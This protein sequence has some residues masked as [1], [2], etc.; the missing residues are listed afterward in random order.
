MES[1]NDEMHSLPQFN[2][3]FYPTGRL[4]YFFLYHLVHFCNFHHFV[5]ESFSVFQSLYII[6]WLSVIQYVGVNFHHSVPQNS[7]MKF[8][9]S[10][11]VDIHTLVWLYIS[12]T[13]KQVNCLLIYFQ[14]LT[15][16]CRVNINISSRA[17]KSRHLI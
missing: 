13:P 12:M 4:Y 10:V 7:I 5:V 15:I 2:Y 17:K 14:V 11:N 1:L 8:H 3:L 9:I 16:Y 6:E